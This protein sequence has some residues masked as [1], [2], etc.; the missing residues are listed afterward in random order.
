VEFLGAAA[1]PETGEGKDNRAA[2]GEVNEK[3]RGQPE[4][5]G[6][7]SGGGESGA[8][9]TI[10]SAGAGA[11]GAALKDELEGLVGLG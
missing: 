4:P 11:L 3:G 7:A 5:G 6:D 1:V 2:A 8:D 10:K 9:I